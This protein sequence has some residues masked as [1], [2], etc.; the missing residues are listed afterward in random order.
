MNN[1]VKDKDYEKIL[2]LSKEQL[3]NIFAQ[4]TPQ[5]IEDLFKLI[6]EVTEND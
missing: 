2:S 4:M 1:K 6:N 5:E 3:T